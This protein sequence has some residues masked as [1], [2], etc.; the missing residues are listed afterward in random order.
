M[1]VALESVTAAGA[2]ESHSCARTSDGSLYC[3]GLQVLGQLGVGVPD[4]P[5]PL[6]VDLP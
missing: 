3:W 6:A 2:G 4:H 5:T 1:P